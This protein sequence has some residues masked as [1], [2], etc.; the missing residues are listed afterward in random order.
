MTSFPFL[1]IR[2]GGQ[3]GVDRAALDAAADLNLP[4]TGWCPKGG[5]AEDRPVPPGVLRDYPRLTE[6]PS[7]RTQ[8]RTAWNVRDAHAT[9]I[10]APGDELA[11]FG[12]TEFTYVM[13]RLVFLRPCRV[14]DVRT[15]TDP[16]A[17]REW[18][19]RTAAG[20]GLGELVLN[21]AGPRESEARGISVAAFRFLIAALGPG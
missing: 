11:P 4:Y 21:V 3:S 6:T 13:A 2:S 9:L 19:A 15:P 16:A 17:V 18:V 1:T 12:G 14:A 7:A 20:L 10:L 8:Q 5:W